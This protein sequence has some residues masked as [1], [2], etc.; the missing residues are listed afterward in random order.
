MEQMLHVRSTG[1][2][3]P[4]GLRECQSGAQPR[5]QKPGSRAAEVPKEIAVKVRAVRDPG[6]WP[7]G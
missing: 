1:E 7:L 5:R 2:G 6:S 3:R 4:H